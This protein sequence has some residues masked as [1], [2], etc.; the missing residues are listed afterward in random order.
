MKNRQPLLI[1]SLCALTFFAYANALFNSFVWDDQIFIVSNPFIRHPQY[2][3]DFFHKQLGFLSAWGSGFENYYRPVFLL[4]FLFDYYFWGLN[5][6]YFHFH[7]II[8]HLT[9]IILVYYFAKQFNR[10]GIFPFM[11]A[12]LFALHPVHTEA[13]TAIFNRMDILV[14]CL[15]L[16]VFLLFSSFLKRENNL[17]ALG[18]YLCSLL[19]FCMSLF[20]KETALLLPLLLLLYDLFFISKRMREMLCKHWLYYVGFAAVI[21]FY[22]SFRILTLGF[23]SFGTLTQEI[24]TSFAKTNFILLPLYIPLQCLSFY[25]QKLLLPFKLNVVHYFVLDR[26]L[27]IEIFFATIMLGLSIYGIWVFRKK[28]PA[29]SFFILWFLITIFPVLQ[30]IPFGNLVAEHYTYLPSVGFCCLMGYTFNYLYEKSSGLKSKWISAQSLVLIIFGVICSFYFGKTVLR[31]FDWRNELSL[32]SSSVEEKPLC[33]KPYT[34]LGNIYVGFGWDVQAKEQYLKAFSLQ[35]GDSRTLSA[36]G[37]LFVR[38]NEIQKGLGLM[39]AAIYSDPRNS[40][41]YH[42]LGIQFNLLKDYDKAIQYLNIA[43]LLNPGRLEFYYDLGLTYVKKGDYS[44]AADE[45]KR[46]VAIDSKYSWGYFGLGLAMSKEGKFEEAKSN[47][48]KAVQLEPNFL[49]MVNELLKEKK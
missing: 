14:T 22:F 7:N 41:A 13:V 18:M 42:K 33:A 21:L 34:N 28:T 5:P 8:L 35:S 12:V 11:A 44:K 32:W 40:F 9:A 27:N 15:S 31:N 49:S 37:A 48:K 19:L 43:K 1:A 30:I 3:P 39:L 6:F 47:F 24:Y 10:N 45:F 29:I 23:S 4:S 46:A 38:N 17:W 25:I 16:S 26:A 20:C 36:L 2:I